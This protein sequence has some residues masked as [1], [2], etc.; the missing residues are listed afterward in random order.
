MESCVQC[1]PK[2]NTSAHSEV[3]FMSWYDK[4][5][6]TKLWAVQKRQQ[7]QQ[8]KYKQLTLAAFL[9]SFL[10]FVYM[11]SLHGDGFDGSLWSWCLGVVLPFAVF[12]LRHSLFIL[13]M[14]QERLSCFAVVSGFAGVK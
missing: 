13:K 12:S 9:F 2:E 1:K 11:C 8:P 7:L 10:S 6:M 4:A 3:I 5:L 14:S